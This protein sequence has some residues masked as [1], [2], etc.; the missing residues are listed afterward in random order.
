MI[1]LIIVASNNIGDLTILH[2]IETPKI[3][4]HIVIG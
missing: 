4:V 1:K 3:D 2:E